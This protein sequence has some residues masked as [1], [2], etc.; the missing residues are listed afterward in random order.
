VAHARGARREL[1]T[2][3]NVD[4]DDHNARALAPIV[5]AAF[6]RLSL[7]SIV[8]QYL[9]TSFFVGAGSSKAALAPE[10]VHHKPC[11]GSSWKNSQDGSFIHIDVSPACC[12]F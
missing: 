9:A 3:V 5:A 1:F 4:K 2:T 12:L 8:R 6:P 11:N 10:R 7:L